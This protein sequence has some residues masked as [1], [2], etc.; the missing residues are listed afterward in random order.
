MTI[1][2]AKHLAMIENTHIGY[3]VRQKECRRNALDV[4]SGWLFMNMY[5]SS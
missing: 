1:E 4:G 2:M 3:P 5:I